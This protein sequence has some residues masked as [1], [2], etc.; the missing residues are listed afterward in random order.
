MLFR[1]GI[2]AIFVRNQSEHPMNEHVK[3]QAI[4]FGS[5]AGGL[6]L[7]YTLMAYLVDLTLMTNPWVGIL[8]WVVTLIL[9]IIA[10]SRAK[11]AMGGFISFKEAFSTFI[12]AYVIYALI[13]TAFSMLLF[14]VVDTAAAAELQEMIIESSVGMMESFGAGEEQIEQ[15]VEAMESQN[16]FGVM[17][18]LQSFFW[19]IVG[20]AVIGLIVA[21]FM[22]KNKP[23]FLEEEVS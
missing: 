4:R 14:N 13:T 18:L 5:I 8:F 6:A 17:G 2:L 11:A 19:G 7:A 3:S 9:L 20:Y 12:V 16:S 10:V 23:D 21:A 15:S 1:E 22:K